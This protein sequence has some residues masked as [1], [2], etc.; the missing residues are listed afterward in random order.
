MYHLVSTVSGVFLKEQLQINQCPPPLSP[1]VSWGRGLFGQ[2]R[3]FLSQ[4]QKRK[5]LDT[6]CMYNFWENWNL[7]TV[8]IG[9]LSAN[10][11]SY[12]GQKTPQIPYGCLN[13]INSAHEVILRRYKIVS[14]LKLL[15]KKN[16]RE[17]QYIWI[18]ICAIYQQCL[19]EK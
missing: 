18:N 8:R 7:K 10:G 11:Y 15:E 9:K 16:G 14:C 3:K 5:R 13:H 17:K 4:K 1:L 6:K 19:L 2:F 12:S